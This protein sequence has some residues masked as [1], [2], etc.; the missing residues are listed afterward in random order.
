MS[1]TKPNTSNVHEPY[2]NFYPDGSSIIVLWEYHSKTWEKRGGKK[3]KCSGMLGVYS[4]LLPDKNSFVAHG[5]KW[6]GHRTIKDDQFLELILKNLS[7]F[8]SNQPKINSENKN[9][10][11][12]ILR[13]L[14]QKNC[15]TDNDLMH[16]SLLVNEN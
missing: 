7:K 10:C 3:K 12:E 16:Y 9:F 2:V 15:I 1:T 6:I 4:P 14:A 5:I 11:K 13:R 8:P